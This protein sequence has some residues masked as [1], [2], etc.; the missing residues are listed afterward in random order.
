MK[1]MLLFFLLIPFFGIGQDQSLSWVNTFDNG[2]TISN[3]FDMEC[4]SDNNTYFAGHFSASVDLDPGPGTA[5]FTASADGDMFIAKYDSTGNYLWGFALEVS[6]NISTAQLALDPD[7]NLVVTGLLHGPGTLDL[8]PS[9]GVAPINSTLNNRFLAKYSPTGNLI[10]GIGT[11]PGGSTSWA[12]NA[13]HTDPN[14]NIYIG[15]QYS[16]TVDFDMNASTTALTTTTSYDIVIS[17]YDSLGNFLW[18]K[19]VA[20][21]NNQ[22]MNDMAIDANQDLIFSGYFGTGTT[23]FDPGSGVFNL[24][25]TSGSTMYICKFSSMGNLIWAKIFTGIG[26]GTGRALEA[27]TSGNIYLTGDFAGTVDFDLEAGIMNLTAG[28]DDVFIAS[29]T[30]SGDYRWAKQVGST[31]A[32]DLGYHITLDKDESPIITGMF[33]ATTDFCPG[34]FTINHDPGDL[35]VMKLDSSGNYK[36][37]FPSMAHWVAFP[38]VNANGHLMLAGTFI[39]TV[40]FDPSVDSF[41]VTSTGAFYLSDLNIDPC[42]QSI[43]DSIKSVSCTENGY[44]AGHAAM[45]SPPYS[46]QWTTSPLTNDSIVPSLTAGGI[47]SFITSDTTGCI[48]S[49]SVAVAGPLYPTAFDLKCNLIGGEFRPGFFTTVTLDAFNHGCDAASG[50]LKFVLDD[51]LTYI[52]ANITPNTISGDTLIWNMLS[53]TFDS[54]HFI[55]RVTVETDITAPMGDHVYLKTII[56]SAAGDVDT[57][58][59]INDYDFQIINSFDPNDKQVYPQ[60]LC[61]EHYTLPN[62]RMTYTVRFQNTGNASAINVYLLD[63]IDPSLNLTSINVISASHPMITEILSYNRVKFEFDN[64]YLP[65][66]TS[67]EA[68][69]HGYVVY[70]IDQ[71][72]SLADGIVIENTAEIYFDFNP[73]IV[74]NTVYNTVIGIIPSCTLGSNEI[75]ENLLDQ[76]KV[77]PNPANSSI[78]IS[79]E[80]TIAQKISLLDVYGRTI[81]TVQP[82]SLQTIFDL[83]SIE[84]GIYFVRVVN[85]NLKQ[86]VKIIK[87]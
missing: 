55:V 46:Y 19:T 43:F 34:P 68:G 77:Y 61:D 71:Q 15:G 59:N 66:S 81:K 3:V 38:Q 36:W 11:D 52:N 39:G 76:V 41:L 33:N 16:G 58:N 72:P 87:Q 56:D 18:V 62:Q 20:G 48:V 74:T 75:T 83:Q 21:P 14:G 42:F 51:Y 73:A 64:I 31:I 47:F 78:T 44:L 30:S 63:Q 5:V 53:L 8:D 28:F 12:A 37:S 13:M 57:S 65:D 45:G 24:T 49:R 23:D 26:N 7:E 67:D 25:A 79:T 35:F 70:E 27:T 40:D 9:A 82:N 50:T 1:K 10:W 32:S 4:D 29:Y 69:S 60:G 84:N 6:A 54:S 85:G 17:K 22:M 86:T 2:G 80:K